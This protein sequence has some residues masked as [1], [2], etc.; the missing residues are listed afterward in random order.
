MR[1]P[2]LAGLTSLALL[3]SGGAIAQTST[4]GGPTGSNLSNPSRAGGAGPQPLNSA[5]STTGS[6]DPGAA[7]AGAPAIGSTPGT[8]IGGTPTSGPPGTGGAAG[9]PSLGGR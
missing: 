4:T 8:N 7:P 1:I 2:I 9:G 6:V 5:G 3:V